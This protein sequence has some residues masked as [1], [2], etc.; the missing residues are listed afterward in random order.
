MVLEL[1]KD[2]TLDINLDETQI[3]HKTVTGINVAAAA[4]M[5]K[6]LQ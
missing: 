4:A 2:E 5:E 6:L 1:G 3:V